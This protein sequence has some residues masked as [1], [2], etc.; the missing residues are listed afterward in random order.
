M[1]SGPGEGRRGI[2]FWTRGP[3][4]G[5]PEGQGSRREWGGAGSGGSSGG[6]ETLRPDACLG[7][8]EIRRLCL[9]PSPISGVFAALFGGDR[10]VMNVA[11]TRHTAQMRYGTQDQAGA[12]QNTPNEEIRKS[13]LPVFLCWSEREGLWE[14]CLPARVLGGWL[15]EDM[16]LSPPRRRACSWCPPTLQAPGRHRPQAWW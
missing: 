11:G 2:S 13:I 9:F 7:L 5:P 14:A 3:G 4:G 15:P 6:G 1:C 8:Q 16:S 10:R 12:Q